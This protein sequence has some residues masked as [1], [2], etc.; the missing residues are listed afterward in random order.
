M[1]HQPCDAQLSETA[2]G[3]A[4]EVNPHGF[5]ILVEDNIRPLPGYF[6]IR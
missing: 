3:K 1:G 2:F 4:A 5:T 6:K